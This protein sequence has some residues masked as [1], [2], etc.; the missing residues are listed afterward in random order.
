MTKNN[1]EDTIF[2]LSSAPGRGGVA[3]V[4]VS[5]T[6]ALSGLNALAPEKKFP[7]RQAVFCSLSRNGKE[8]DRA[9]ALYFKSP[10]SFTGED[11]VEYHV[12]GG[13]AVVDALLKAL[14]AQDGHRPAEPGEFTKRAFENGK[15]DLTAAEAIA[16]LINAETEG[17]REQA[18]MQMEGALEKLYGGW[19]KTLTKI[20]A[21]QEAEIEFP[22]DDM[23][24]GVAKALR[25]KIESLIAEINIHLDDNHRGERLREG[26]MIAIVGAP[27]AGKSSLLNALA[28]RDVAIV[29]ETAGTTRDVIEA[30]LD[31]AG[32]PVSIAD[33]AGLRDKTD[34]SIEIEGMSR[35]RKKAADADLCLAVF[36]A[37]KKPDPET[38]AFLDND[39]KTIAVWNKNDLARQNRPG[40]AL[41]AK[42]GEGIPA[43][44]DWITQKI[45]DSYGDFNSKPPPLTRP[46][47]RHLVNEAKEHLTRA[48]NA[49]LPE[50]AAEDLRMALR[51]LGRLTGHIDVEN[52][53]DVIFRDFC[54]GK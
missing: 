25:P 37:S 18:L 33:T 11:V 7:A 5:G 46:R 47:H 41:S 23:P 52:L 15:L 6:Q 49:K 13:K 9:L 10:K 19:A 3:V 39:K 50:L 16:D 27:N 53:L 29:S 14:A 22:E 26:V 24:E 30:H 40:I 32:Y 34:D 17:Q 1:H 48:L 35:A 4:R 38:L 21:H 36:D 28:R 45:H 2:A 12:H 44:I 8:I 51:C 20:L 54:I 31:L 43:L 42:T